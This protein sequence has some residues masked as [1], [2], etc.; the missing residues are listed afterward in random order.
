MRQFHLDKLYRY[1][2]H[3]TSKIKYERSSLKDIQA[4]DKLV[5]ILILLDLLD[6]EDE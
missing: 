1:I 5:Y 2:L 3:F 6:D 4:V